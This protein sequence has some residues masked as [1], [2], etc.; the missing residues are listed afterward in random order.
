[1]ESV[2]VA[3]IIENDRYTPISTSKISSSILAPMKKSMMD[4][5]F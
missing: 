3:M 5:P 1:M 4:K 2:S